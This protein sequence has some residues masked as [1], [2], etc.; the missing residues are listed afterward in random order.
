[1]SVASDIYGFKIFIVFLTSFRH[2]GRWEKERFPAARDK[3]GSAE[4]PGEQI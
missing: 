2:F 4:L 1:M 3:I